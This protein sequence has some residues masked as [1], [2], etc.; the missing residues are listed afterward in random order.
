MSG[1]LDRL[2]SLA[3]FKEFQP[4]AFVPL[5]HEIRQ[6]LVQSVNLSG[7]HLASNLGAVE[8]TMALH[9]VFDSPRDRIFFDTGHQAYVHKIL[10]GRRSRL[11]SL[12]KKGGLAPFPH[13]EESPHDPFGPGH[14]GTA[15]SAAMG[16]AWANRFLGS[17][18]KVIAVLGDAALSSGMT[19]EALNHLADCGLDVLIVLN[20]NGRSISPT[21][22]GLEF[23]KPALTR[24]AILPEAVDGH[25]T[26]ALVKVFESA[27]AKRGPRVV[28]VRTVK[29]RGY[30]PAEKDPLAY[31]SVLPG[32]LHEA[33]PKGRPSFTQVFGS[34]L[35]RTAEATPNLTVLCPAMSEGSG[36]R[37]FAELYPDRFFDTGMAEQHTLGM[38]A[39]L[40]AAGRRPIVAIYSTFLQRAWDQLVHDIALP[41]LPVVLAVDRAGSAGPDGPTHAGI[42]DA[43]LLCAVPGMTVMAPADDGELTGMFD[44][45]LS[46]T[47]PSA[48]R[49]P[50]ALCPAVLPGNQAQVELGKASVLRRGRTVALLAWGALVAPALEAG[51]VLDATVVSMRFVQ[52]LDLGLLK[53]LWAEHRAFVTLEDNLVRGGG[54]EA[55]LAALN[56]I[57][58][59]KILVMKGLRPEFPPVGEREALLAE[60]GLDVLGIQRTVEEIFSRMEVT[61]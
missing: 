23:W 54:G 33:A 19:L 31:H 28:F 37:Q 46:I 38:A 60:W 32:F 45:G 51:A 52:P 26:E 58:S 3:A 30:P 36:L 16:H 55:I 61:L 27:S 47:G 2:T 9:W 17:S 10:T 25:D 35:C 20:D 43:G 49:Y 34:W 12:R 22:G 56:P 53:E 13:P 21:V 39:G 5:A 59:G 15:L 4:E 11:A 48:V 6:E 18:H 57:P 14:G 8:L 40:A 42:F 7:G 41:R 1:W 50:K 29:G 24:F 44:L